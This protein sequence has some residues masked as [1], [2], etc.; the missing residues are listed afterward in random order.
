M[1]G[2]LVH[3]HKGTDEQQQTTISCDLC[4]HILFLFIVIYDLCQH[5]QHFLSLSF[6]RKN[7]YL[8]FVPT[9]FS[10][11]SL[12]QKIVC[13]NFCQHISYICICVCIEKK[14]SLSFVICASTHHICCWFV[15]RTLLYVCQLDAVLI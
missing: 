14:S 13:C 4:Q 9:H 2:K 5:G 15:S 7:C 3:L 11:L 6:H 12:L 1:P 10:Y 8:W